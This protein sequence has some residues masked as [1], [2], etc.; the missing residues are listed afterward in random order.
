MYSREERKRAVELWL[1]HDKTSTA[2]TNEPGYPSRKMLASWHRDFIKEKETGVIN[3]HSQR[4]GK[5]T[6]EQKR[7]AVKCQRLN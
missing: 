7:A 2:V 6:E 5:Y 4:K 1:K 3:D